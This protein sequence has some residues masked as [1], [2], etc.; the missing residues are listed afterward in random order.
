MRAIQGTARR[1]PTTTKI[2]TEPAGTHGI[3]SYTAN[4][5][6]SSADEV[7]YILL[8]MARIMS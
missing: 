1:C 3:S 4:D 6:C 2:P 5:E 7:D 8:I